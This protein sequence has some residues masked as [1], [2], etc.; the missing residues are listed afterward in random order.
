MFIIFDGTD[1]KRRG[2]GWYCVLQLWS[3]ASNW[4]AQEYLSFN[5]HDIG[6]VILGLRLSTGVAQISHIANGVDVA[7]SQ[8]SMRLLH[9]L[10]VVRGLFQLIVRVMSGGTRHT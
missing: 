1:A 6:L 7:K 2:G 8:S 3:L 9:V 5:H 4:T 10:L